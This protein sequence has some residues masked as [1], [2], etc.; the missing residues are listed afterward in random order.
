MWPAFRRCYMMDVLRRHYRMRII[1]PPQPFMDTRRHHIC[2]QFP[3]A[4][5]PMSCF[6]NPALVGAP[7]T[8]AARTMRNVLLISRQV[9]HCLWL[10]ACYWDFPPRN[11][12]VLAAWALL[13]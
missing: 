1:T 10:L 5:F 7:G 2:T 4:V 13:P 3:H 12:G 11:K 9:H 8:G 6:L